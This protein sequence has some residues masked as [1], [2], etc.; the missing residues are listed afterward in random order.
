MMRKIL[1]YL[2]F[3]FAVQEASASILS[4][5][6]QRKAFLEAQ[7][8]IDKGGSPLSFSRKDVLSGYPLYPY[9][10]YQWLVK[11]L[12]QTKQ[13]KRFLRYYKDTRYA[14]LL[15]YKWQIYLAKHKNWP[16]YIAQYQKT[17]NT[18]LQCYYYRAKYNLGAKTQA[19]IGAKKLWVIGKSQ[20]SECNPIFKV[21]L[22][23][24]YLTR[25]M[26]WQRFDSAVTKGNFS[27][28]K[29]VKGLMAKKD[30]QVAQLW[31]KVHSNPTLITNK[32]F[33]KHKQAQAGLIF[34]HGIER[35]AKKNL[36]KAISLWDKRQ[37]EFTINP[38]TRRRVEQRLA[39]SL[40]Y[41]H[42]DKAYDRLAALIK[43]AD[44]AKEWR[45]RAALKMQN[46]PAVAESIS[47][48]SKEFKKKEKWRYWLA[49]ASENNNKPKVANFIYSNLAEERSFYGYL[50][51]EKLNKEYKLSNN[52][53][54]VA[55]EMFKR[56]KHKKSF[57]VVAELIAV[58]K[59]KEAQRQWWFT[60]RKLDK[61]Q[62]LMAAKYAEELNWKQVAIFTLAKAKYWDDV[63]VRFPLA[64]KTQVQKN[65]KK[66]DLN[67]ALIFGL[68]RR[69]SAFNRNAYSP[70]GA[71]GLMQIMPKTGKQIARELKEKWVGKVALFNP[72]TNLKYGAYYYKK[73]LNQ[74]N[75]H[76]ALAAAAYN[77]GPHRVKRWLP[78]KHKM[79]A[80][81]WIETIPFNETRAYVSA[82]LT[83]A[84][85]YQK[86]L[87]KNLLTMKDF[88]KDVLPK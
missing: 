2:I 66:Q 33:L 14:G 4:L 30:Q 25:D 27:V 16:E 21:L 84:L 60:I 15:R 17:N 34:A 45:V 77:A 5:D 11:H 61:K 74:F 32:N 49:R 22:G 38:A 69:E 67:P 1:F 62:I 50:S 12:N 79:A 36:N 56:F 40:A 19:L 86:Q 24:K 83:Y 52:P 46:W 42:D 28:A 31:L 71:R 26:L 35:L 82:V 87:K 37:K 54:Q 75:G 85:I 81:I 63:A 64:Y 41:N 9:I 8:S 59:P 68:I 20:P 72:A 73:L 3:I 44:K 53:I 39:M 88:M 18:R 65:A 47:A 57:L 13:I 51:A 55:P 23:S 76:Y 80:D 78:D 48:L 70:V 58:E 6:K 7:I 43:P 10:Q 29:Y